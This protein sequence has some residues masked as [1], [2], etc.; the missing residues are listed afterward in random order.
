MMQP[1]LIM[2]CWLL[3]C[4]LGNLLDCGL[5]LYSISRGA[6][7]LNPI[8][9]WL[10]QESHFLFASVKILVFAFAIDFLSKNKPETLKW[11][12]LFYLWVLAWHLS[13]IFII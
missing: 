11:V 7:E 4:H 2:L 13:Q 10:L 12:G 6:E 5:T 9:N 1:Q 3:I 8:M